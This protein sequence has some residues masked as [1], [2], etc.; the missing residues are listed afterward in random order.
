MAA[1]MWARPPHRRSRSCFSD[2]AAAI[3]VAALDCAEEEN[4]EVCRAYD[5]HFYPTFRVSTALP[6]VG[7]PALC[8]PSVLPRR[9]HRG[10]SRGTLAGAGV[11]LQLRGARVGPGPPLV[12]R[13]LWVVHTH[14]RTPRAPTGAP[15]ERG[16]RG[17]PT[18]WARGCSGAALTAWGA[19]LSTPSRPCPAG[20]FPPARGRARL[21]Q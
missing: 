3:R 14:A 18:R 1:R 15:R 17:L 5:V 21:S 8:P 4:H 19:G 13:P 6:S 10:G 11:W 9:D 2:W 12:L 20:P 7:G 16:R